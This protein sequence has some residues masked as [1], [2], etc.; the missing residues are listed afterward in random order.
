MSVDTQ[1]HRPLDDAAA[2]PPIEL[3]KRVRTRARCHACGDGVVVAVCSHCARL[4]CR[5]H[6]VAAG[7]IGPRALLRLLRPD[8]EDEPVAGKGPPGDVGSIGSGRAMDGKRSGEDAASTP[9]KDRKEVHDDEKPQGGKKEPRDRAKQSADDKRGAGK[10][11]DAADQAVEGRRRQRPRG[12]TQRRYCTSCVPRVRP[13]D[14][15]LIAAATTGGLGAFVVPVNPVAGGVLV[16]V[17]ALRFGI[18]AA[19]GVRR[20]A[21][22]SAD[23][24]ADLVLNPNLRKVKVRER[25]R[26]TVSLSDDR[27]YEAIVE[28]IVGSVRVE[29]N[30]SRIHRSELDRHRRRTRSDPTTV[31]AG[32]LVLHGPA[33][34]AFRPVSDAAT[35][36]GSA[37]VLEPRIADNGVLH[38]PDGHG[39]TRW[40]P[41]F[42]YDISPPDEGWTLP[43]WLSPNIAADLERHVLELHVQWCTRGPERTDAGVPLRSIATLELNVPANWGTIEHMSQHGTDILIGPPVPDDVTGIG[44]RTLTWKKIPF[45]KGTDRGSV[46]F[47]VRF[48]DVIDLDDEITGKLEVRFGGAISGITRVGLYRTD[49]GLVSRL[50]GTRKPMTIVDVTYALSLKGLRYQQQRAVP[51][52]SR[53]CRPARNCDIP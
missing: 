38:T 7:P 44:R 46:R 23:Q 22:Q 21:R 13:F 18:R 47:A 27:R 1:P 53:G 42:R 3:V 2:E 34:A 15:E 10:R 28:D 32:H 4:L 35:N 51:D 25:I 17:G 16:A 33:R 9:T 6:D 52:R 8:P 26:G 40:R 37:L 45:P 49:G 39:D 31:A 12:A 14:A 19:L 30:W 41:E 43:V 29:G 5:K 50:D 36:G 20:R 24:S 48:S 11:P